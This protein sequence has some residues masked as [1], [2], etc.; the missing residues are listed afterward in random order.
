MGQVESGLP[1]VYADTMIR[2][3][4]VRSRRSLR[5][6]TSQAVAA[7]VFRAEILLGM[8]G[9]APLNVGGPIMTYILMRIVTGKAA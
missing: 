5:H 3:E 6:V 1:L 7:G 4:K 8:A 9:N 2:E